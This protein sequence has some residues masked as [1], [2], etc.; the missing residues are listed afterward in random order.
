MNRRHAVLG[1]VVIVLLTGLG[2]AYFAGLGPAPGGD[3]SG[4]TITDF[5]TAT[6]DDNGGTNGDGTAE[7]TETPPF[8]FTVDEIEECGQTCRDVTVTLHN[9][10]DM[11]ATG[12]TVYTRIYA[13]EDNTDSDDVVWEGT[14]DVG[15]LDADTSYTTTRRVELSFQEGLAIERNDGWITILTTVDSDRRTVTFQNSEQVA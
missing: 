9:N 3:D 1:A 5:P 14:D 15:S 13:G 4:D 10:L 7:T 11:T 12:I 2:A 8:T 6:G